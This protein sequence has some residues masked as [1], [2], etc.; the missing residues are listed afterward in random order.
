[1]KRYRVV[2]EFDAE[3]DGEAR[4]KARL[5]FAEGVAGFKREKAGEATLADVERASFYSSIGLEDE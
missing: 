4:A 5:M 2:I 1:V 3:T